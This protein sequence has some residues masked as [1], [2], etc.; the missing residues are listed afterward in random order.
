MKNTFR[1]NARN[2]L[3]I[4]IASGFGAV[5]SASAAIS[6]SNSVNIGTPGLADHT[7]HDP[8]SAGGPD[9]L[10]ASGSDLAE[11]LAAT[12][13]GNNVTT[14]EASLGAAAW[15]NGALATVYPIN[16]NA[17]DAIDHA[18]YGA[19]TTGTVITLDLGATFDLSKIDVYTGWG[20][21]GRDDASFDL[22][23]SADNITY[24][25][26]GSYAKVDQATSAPITA[27][28]SFTDDGGADIGTGIQYVRL[29]VTASDNGRAG[30]V[31]IDV[32]ETVTVPEP[33]SVA[34]LALCG[35]AAI[36]RRR[37]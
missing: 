22:L 8:A 9:F 15:T 12:V 20:D 16:G 31:E 4:G 36:A 26:L 34:L 37:R 11:G 35:F 1:L 21:N 5:T 10:S 25:T 7:A 13:T 6:L 23:V 18:A 33:G 28:H 27:L 19:V 30:I 24:V 14:F 17:G 32:F 3:A 2:I 29:N